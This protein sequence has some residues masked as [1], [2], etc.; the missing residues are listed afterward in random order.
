[1]KTS[2][3]T[4]GKLALV[5]ESLRY[6]DQA[7]LEIDGENALLDER[8]GEPAV[9][10]E[11]VV[12]HARADVLHAAER[13]AAILLDGKTDEL[14]D[15]ELSLARLAELRA[16]DFELR[17][18]LGIAVE[19]DDEAAS[20][21][22]RFDDE[23]G[24]GA[25]KDLGAGRK[26][27]WVLARAL[28]DEC[29]VEPVRPAH[30]ADR[31]KW[32]SGRWRPRGTHARKASQGR[33]QGAT[34][35]INTGATED[36][37]WRRFAAVEGP[38]DV[39]GRDALAN[40]LQKSALVRA[41]AAG[42]DDRAERAGDASLAADDL[43]DV[44]GRDAQLEDDDAVPFDSLDTDLVRVVHETPCQVLDELLHS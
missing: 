31:D 39:A 3:C 15:V 5:R 42:T 32:R 10:L 8:E 30:A 11:H 12:R 17:S 26:A 20:G 21:A 27:L 36:T 9:E 37:A 43:A 2:I 40:D 19:P 6:Q 14:E 4:V 38:G 28:D 13:A 33:T 24:L 35:L 22:L 44:L 16:R 41:G 34:V 1:V 7:A 29:T 25:H 18:P 23:G